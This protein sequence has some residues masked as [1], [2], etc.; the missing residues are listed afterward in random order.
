MRP[1]IGSCALLVANHLFGVGMYSQKINTTIFQRLTHNSRFKIASSIYSDYAKESS[2]ILDFG[3]GDGHIFSYY[4]KHNIRCDFVGYDV[5]EQ[6]LSQASLVVKEAVKLT[7][8]INIVRQ[9]RYSY[10]SC[11]ETLEHIPDGKIA[12]T[13][14][15]L[16]SLLEP[17]GKLVISVPLESGLPSLIKQLIRKLSGQKEKIAT[18]TAVLLSSIY[19]TSLIKRNQADPGHTGFDYL[20]LRRLVLECGLKIEKTIY[21]PVSIFGPVINSQVF[22]VCEQ[23]NI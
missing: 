5:S 21:S 11:M 10:I 3:T 15:V 23:S 19:L 13:L 14:L 17:G 12:D 6:M 2:K 20:A 16:R 7:S 18:P 1:S 4:L 8:D 22:W 9:Y